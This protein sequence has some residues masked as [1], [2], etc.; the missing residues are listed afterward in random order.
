MASRFVVNVYSRGRLPTHERALVRWRLPAPRRVDYDPGEGWR[1]EL[2]R[3][4]G[5][6]LKVL[7]RLEDGHYVAQCLEPDIAVQART[8]RGL[9][10]SL[11]LAIVGNVV[12]A[13]KNHVEPFSNF[14]RAPERY[15]K[16]FDTAEVVVKRPLV[17]P[18]EALQEL[19][20]EWR[21]ALPEGSQATLAVT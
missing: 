21:Q 2:K 5:L 7:V 10:T 15:W 4:K 19:D 8:M 13:W 18:S 20:S 3:L 12:L 14:K 1:M 11:A 16:E 9:M 17:L 6:D